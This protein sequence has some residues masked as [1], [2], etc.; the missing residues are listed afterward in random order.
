MLNAHI[1][2]TICSTGIQNRK[3]LKLFCTTN[4][5]KREV[6]LYEQTYK[7]D[8]IERSL[9]LNT[10]FKTQFFFLFLLADFIRDLLGLRVTVT[11]I[12]LYS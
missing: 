6:L 10:Q 3:P 7:T 2:R 4:V 9:V 12:Q 11:L 5:Q 1:N 8:K